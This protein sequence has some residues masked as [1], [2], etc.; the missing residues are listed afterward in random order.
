MH[1]LASNFPTVLH[2][3]SIQIFMGANTATHP[4]NETVKNQILQEIL[5]KT[6]QKIF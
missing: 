5:K 4:Q 2:G 3:I 1:I 6:I